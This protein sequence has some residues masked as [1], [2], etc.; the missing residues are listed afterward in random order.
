MCVDS[1]FFR[2]LSPLLW[3]A[4]EDDSS[5]HRCLTPDVLRLHCNDIHFLQLSDPW[6]TCLLVLTS[7]QELDIATSNP[8]IST[9]ALM[10]DDSF[11]EAYPTLILLSRLNALRLSGGWLISALFQRSSATTR[12]Y[13][14]RS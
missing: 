6:P 5:T 11:R 2:I 1:T 3:T 4:Y 14:I 8:Q 7:L 12:A 13:R 10:L 9:L